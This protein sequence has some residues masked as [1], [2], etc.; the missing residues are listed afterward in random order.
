[1]SQISNQNHYHSI[2]SLNDLP[3]GK[4]KRVVI[5]NVAIALFHI[6]QGFFAI[7]DSC[8]HQGASLAFGSLEGCHI[9][10]P[11]HGA[12]FDIRNGNVVSLPALR[13]VKSYPVKI[14]NGTLFISS[15]PNSEESPALLRL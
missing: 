2:C 6:D 1:M 10:C 7:E 11:R 4:S 9:A 8:S 15:I 13:G 14:E 3:E 12:L 5:D